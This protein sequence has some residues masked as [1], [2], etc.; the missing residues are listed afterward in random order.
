MKEY[1]V[2]NTIDQLNESVKNDWELEKIVSSNEFIISRAYD[3]ERCSKIQKERYNKGIEELIDQLALRATSSN[4]NP[5]NIKQAKINVMNE[6]E[7]IKND[8][9]KIEWCEEKNKFHL[10]LNIYVKERL[11]RPLSW[12]V[13]LSRDQIIKEML[14]KY[15]N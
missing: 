11:Y 1:K 13:I 7:K 14:D 9:Y 10:L 15:E 4:I 6:V 5:A 12:E 3:Y 8:H 2:V